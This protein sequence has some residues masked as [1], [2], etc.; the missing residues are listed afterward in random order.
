[1]HITKDKVVTLDFKLWDS[2]GELLDSSEDNDPL[3]YLH[4]ASNIPDGLEA[5]L[6]GKAL[7]DKVDITLEPAQGY[8]ERLDELVQKAKQEDIQGLDKFEEGMQFPA[9]TEQGVFVFTIIEVSED[10]VLLDGNHPLAGETIRFAVTVSEIREASA[11][12]AEHGHAHGPGGHH[13]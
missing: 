13:H 7:G 10:E 9:E 1:M 3:L 6:E 5:A 11:E 2:S 12:E 4:G 8:G